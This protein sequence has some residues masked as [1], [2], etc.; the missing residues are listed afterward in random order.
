MSLAIKSIESFL[1]AILPGGLVIS[2]AISRVLSGI[3]AD[4]F[5][6]AT[7]RNTDGIENGLLFFNAGA[8]RKNALEGP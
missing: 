7:R 4:C 5:S 6:N 2:L 1:K 3:G 8:S